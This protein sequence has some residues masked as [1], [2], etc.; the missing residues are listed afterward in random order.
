LTHSQQ[1]GRWA[2]CWLLFAATALS[3]LDRQVLS[4][5]APTLTAEFGMNN[6]EYSRVVFAFQLSYTVM[7]AVG[8]RLMDRL[9][10]R[11]GR[12]SGLLN[13]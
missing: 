4:V 1:S 5:L 12:P 11:T 8:G 7:F 2:L 6:T 3:F 10:T 9:G 13:V